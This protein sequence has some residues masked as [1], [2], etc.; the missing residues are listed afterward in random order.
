MIALILAIGLAWIIFLLTPT[1][2]ENGIESSFKQI[3]F[4]S[5]LMWITFNVLVLII[6]YLFLLTF[7]Y[8]LGSIIIKGGL[9]VLQT[10]VVILLVATTI[11][12]SSQ[13]HF[14]KNKDLGFDVKDLVIIDLRGSDINPSALKKTLIDNQ[15]IV[16]ATWISSPLPPSYSSYYS[17]EGIYENSLM[18]QTLIAEDDVFSTL[19]IDLIAGRGSSQ[20]ISTKKEVVINE[21]AAR[22]IGTTQDAIGRQLVNYSDQS[23]AYTIIGIMKDVNFESLHQTTQP[24]LILISNPELEHFLLVK[25]KS[26]QTTRAISFIEETSKNLRINKPF[27]YFVLQD[28]YKNLYHKEVRL[29][30]LLFF[31]SLFFVITC[32]YSMYGLLAY[33]I[34]YQNRKKIIS[35]YFLHL[36][37]TPSLI[38]YSSVISWPYISIVIERFM[39]SYAYRIELSDTPYILSA[40]LV[41][42]ISALIAFIV[43]IINKYPKIKIE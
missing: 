27:T 34:Y 15:T 18:L 11:Q 21:T 38:Y 10:G 40:L 17:V 19:G 5:T 3:V 1:I 14:M 32:C 8:H 41:I 35:P 25:L 31:A 22:N 30:K 26:D 33:L 29:L 37:L 43:F 39:D 36:I 13:I 4:L 12:V 6:G 28:I 2:I 9:A 23:V 42:S 16:G 7:P 24:L 20:G